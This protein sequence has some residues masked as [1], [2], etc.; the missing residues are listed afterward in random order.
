VSLGGSGL[1][2]RGLAALLAAA[3]LA[4]GA[5]VFRDYG[6]HWDHDVNRDYGLGSLHAYF[7]LF[8]RAP[9]PELEAARRRV[10]AKHEQ[11]RGPAFE[12]L[13]AGVEL[14]LGARDPRE[15]AFARHLAT[16]AAFAAGV[17][18]FFALCA[19]HFES[20]ALGLLGALALVLTP[21]IFAHAFYDSTDIAFLSLFVASSLTLLRL[22][23]RPGVGRALVH[24]LVCA[25]LMDVRNV[26]ALV[27]ALTVLLLGVEVAR[28][29][30]AAAKLRELGAP[31][32][33][34]LAALALL[35]PVFWPHLWGA[36][37]SRW[38][39]SL[40]RATQTG[41][42][43]P[44]LY[45]GRF[46]PGDRVPWHYNPVWMAITIPIPYLAA[47]GFGACVVARD[48]LRGAGP[49]R[50]RRGEI[51]LVAWLGVPLLVPILLGSTLY[52]DWRHHYFVYPAL[53]A[54]ALAGVERLWREARSGVG[55]L[56]R[57]LAGCALAGLAAGVVPVASSMQQSHPHQNVYFNALAGGDLRRR[58]ELDYWGLSYRQGLEW[59]LARDPRSRVP[60]AVANHA[61]GFNASILPAGERRRLRFV[62]P[63]DADY[64]VS[65]FRWHPGDYP[66]PEEL[67]AIEVDGEKILAIYRVPARGAGAEP[68]R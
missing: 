44:V 38:I 22:L 33:V 64:F 67:H 65:N 12:L 45:L 60:V 63:A 5:A 8:G 58:F 57:G 18:C 28:E 37:V 46:V 25:L 27:P 35:I 30:G 31:M 62:A 48:W 11:I 55:R 9:P 52:D 34:Y 2:I 32:L 56:R 51:V 53:L 20:R 6:I 21:R 1:R 26:G 40:R 66:Y 15:V 36:P 10:A 39:D 49:W 13:L 43:L 19:R 47:F 14:G 29:R 16:W 41:W 7:E 68:R 24:A 61:G 4:L 42:G 54:I 50:R 3:C 59:I 23:E 17:A